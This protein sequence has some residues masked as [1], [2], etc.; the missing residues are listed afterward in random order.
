MNKLLTVSCLVLALATPL[1][2]AHGQQR[3]Q[4]QQRRRAPRPIAQV[5]AIPP[6]SP[7]KEFI[8]NVPP[9]SGT[10]KDGVYSNEYFGLQFT[11]PAGWRVADEQA[12]RQLRQKGAEFMARDS[13]GLK[14][15]MQQAETQTVS[16]F[17]IGK[18]LPAESGGSTVMIAGVAEAVPT[19]LFTSGEEYLGQVK[20]LLLQTATKP[21]F[22]GPVTKE[23]IGGVEFATM[24][25]RISLNGISVNQ[26]MS[27]TIRKGHAVVLTRGYK[28]EQGK[29]AVD[30]A[31]KSI[32]FK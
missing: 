29:Q 1:Q 16:L 14:P 15:L 22:D 30:E 20:R 26:L 25:V 11:V 7:P 17:T 6:P 21:E 12:A 18:I 5:R 23:N 27:A 10:F 31:I 32:T 3:K 13:P 24:R 9:G 8:A 28:D 19:W 2:S 4:Q